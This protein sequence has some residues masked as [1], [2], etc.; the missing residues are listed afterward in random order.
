MAELAPDSLLRIP[1]VDMMMRDPIVGFATRTIDAS[2]TYQQILPTALGGFN[3]GVGKVFVP[4]RSRIASWLGDPA[5]GVRPHNAA[6]RLLREVLFAV[7]DYLHIWAYRVIRERRPDLG[8]GSLGGEVVDLEDLIFCHLL[9]EA[10][11][12]AGLDYW[13]LS[14][15]ELNDVVDLGTAVDNLTIPYHERQRAEVRRFCPSLEVQTPGFFATVV[16][17][18][19]GGTFPGFDPDALRHSPLILDWVHKELQYGRLQREY[20]RL[21][22]S[23]LLGRRLDESSARLRR[24]CEYQKPWQVALAAEIGELLWAKVKHG[25]L[26]AFSAASALDDASYH[27]LPDRLDFRFVNAQ[28]L[29]LDD[30]GV[31]ARADGNPESTRWLL[32]QLVGSYQLDDAVD[33]RAV[34]RALAA[35]DLVILRALLRN[36][37]RLTAADGAPP[38]TF[39]L[40]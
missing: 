40:S 35:G 20:T 37:N 21:W 10:V 12:V 32:R 2:W 7:H 28:H 15:V 3:P 9:T 22:F 34:E 1:L 23:Y 19:C 27:R 25:R 26:E 17:I 18:Y 38:L 14:C 6:D 39:F 5:Q 4:A 16:E 13:Y 31:L 24:P 33:R 29:D 30:D 8:F 36:A 11:A